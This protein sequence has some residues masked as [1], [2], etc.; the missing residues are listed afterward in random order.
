MKNMTLQQN[1][2]TRAL[3]SLRKLFSQ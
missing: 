1:T 3:H 2:Y